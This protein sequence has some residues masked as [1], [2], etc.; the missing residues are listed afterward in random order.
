VNV[1]ISQEHR[2]DRTPDGA[3]W[4]QGAFSL[5]YFAPYLEVFDS[6]RVVARVRNVATIP[7]N[8]RRADSRQVSFHGVPYYVG[9]EQFLLKWRHVRKALK[10][11]VGPKDAVILR[12][13]SQIAA[14]IEPTLYRNR[15]PYA[16]EVMCDPFAMF[17]AGCNDHLLRPL[18]QRMFYRQMR[19]QCSRATAVSYVTEQSLQR[20]Y[21]PAKNALTA[22]YSNVEMP[23]A[24]YVSTARS[25][26]SKPSPL[27][28]ISVASLDQ[29][30]KGI[31]VLIDAIKIAVVKGPEL[32]LAVIGD[33]VL[34]SQLESRANS[35]NG[36]VRFIGHVSSGASIREYLDEA[37]LFVLPSRTEGLPRALIEA[38]ARALPC[39]CSAVG[40]IPELL[41][42][43]DLIPAGD[44][45]ALYSKLCEV[46]AS[47]ERMAAMSARNLAKAQHY[48]DEALR[49][50]RSGFYCNVKEM[51]QAWIKE[52]EK[53]A[54]V[55]R[56]DMS[57]R[58]RSL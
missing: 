42:Y 58:S 1:V 28:V 47:P 50:R 33:G 45:G 36:R 17:A 49:L 32:R 37:H 15:H 30:Y 40:G 38:M 18:F 35:L 23:A 9:P 16:L 21:P 46:M 34:R 29:P 4:T 5:S 39:V 12:V 24:A 10:T 2:F 55:L 41:P 51:T 8:A 43:S 52:R 53:T 14:G 27:N 3:V 56:C 26:V 19:K 6:V 48:R 44:P 11:C 25:F 22:S 31:D 7:L 54:A 20:R 13:Q 57:P